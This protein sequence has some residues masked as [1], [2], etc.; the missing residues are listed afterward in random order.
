MLPNARVG[1]KIVI[2]KGC[3]VPYLLREVS[4]H[5]YILVSNCYIHGIM[6]GEVWPGEGTDLQE[7]RII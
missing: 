2:L 4:D 3:E 5:R 1:D 7:I 6:H